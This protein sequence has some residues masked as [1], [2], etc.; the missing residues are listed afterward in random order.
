MIVKLLT[1][2]HLEIQSLKGGCT[3]SSEST[4]VKMSNCW[5]SHA[6]AHI[7]KDNMQIK[8]LQ[9]FVNESN[10]DKMA[11]MVDHRIVIK[12]KEMWKITSCQNSCFI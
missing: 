2:H 9:A 4:L 5:Q 8:K 1:E 3:G 7:F 12:T 6:T 11:F 10:Y